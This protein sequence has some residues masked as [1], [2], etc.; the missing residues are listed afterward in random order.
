[1]MQMARRGGHRSERKIRPEEVDGYMHAIRDSM[2][3]DEVSKRKPHAVDNKRTA[4]AVG[5][6]SDS[7]KKPVGALPLYG[8]AK[9]EPAFKATFLVNQTKMIWKPKTRA[10][11]PYL[12]YLHL[13]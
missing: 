12:G 6:K 2:V 8:A 9:R 3:Q 13:R 1:M 11:E 7:A 10:A 5:E 4:K